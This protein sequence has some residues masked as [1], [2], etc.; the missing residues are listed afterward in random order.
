M[1]MKHLCWLLILI[2]SLFVQ[3]QAQNYSLTEYNLSSSFVND[4]KVSPNGRHLLFNTMTYTDG[5]L[6]SAFYIEDL[7]N[8]AKKKLGTKDAYIHGWI[9]DKFVVFGNSTAEYFIQNI[10]TLK[11]ETITCGF[12]MYAEPLLI[13]KE[14]TVVC[15]IDTKQTTYQIYNNNKL[16]KTLNF[17]SFLDANTFDVAS[18]SILELVPQKKNDFSSLD[19]YQFN[20]TADTRNK[21][22][23][24]PSSINSLILKMALRAGK[25]YYLQQVQTYSKVEEH[26][27]D[28]LTV[29]LCSYDLATKQQTVLHTF[30]EG[31]E[32]LNMEVLGNGK[33]L[34]LTK[35]HKNDNEEIIDSQVNDIGAQLGFDFGAK[36]QVLSKINKKEN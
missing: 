14:K 10:N 11:M 28:K 17:T 32:C 36:L 1:T 24:L 21:I 18:N 6:E 4:F 35:D 26:L 12:S 13:S 20:Y 31:T 22:A 8:G 27:W 16:E 33:F 5:K 30:D 3:A 23:T 15:E 19:V 34:L 25:L 2:P 7:T 9:D 29:K